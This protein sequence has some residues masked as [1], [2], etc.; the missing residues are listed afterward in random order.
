MV[1]GIMISKQCNFHCGHCMVNSSHKYSWMEDGVLNKFYELVEYNRPDD[2][3]ILGGE[4]F[5]HIEKIEEMVSIIKKNCDR[6]T[7]FTNGSFL[8]NDDISERVKNLGII[9]RVSDD[10]Y[11]RKFWTDKLKERIEQSGYWIVSKD[12]CEEMIPVGRA[13]EE[14]K[15]LKYNMGC[16]LLTGRYDRDFYPNAERYMVMMDGS[17][18]LY[19]ATIE[20]SLAN[21]FEDENITYELLVEREKVFHNYLFREVIHCQE[22]NYMGKMCNLCQKYK[23]TDEEILFENEHVAYT[24]DYR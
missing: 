13:Y 7:V 4:P 15:H 18:N 2:V 3:Y 1:L 8:L 5:L 22:D 10:R 9:V 23:I 21:V 16:S 11:H 6:I 17:V 12:E 19:C 14:F 20:A 24:S